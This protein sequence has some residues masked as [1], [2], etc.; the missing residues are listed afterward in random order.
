MPVISATQAPVFD[1]PG[2]RVV[3][4][5]APSRGSTEIAA[6]RLRLAPG[7][8]S[9]E[10]VL[11]AEEVFI[12]LA[13]SAVADLDGVPHRVAAGD[14]LVVPPRVPFRIATDGDVAFEAVA[15]MRAG[16]LATVDSR[17]F[18]PPWAV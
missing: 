6:W 16:G 1:Q 17:T 3:G 2:T 5:A 18:A 13:G 11:T 8:A 14:A 4:L 15:C 12:A 7:A 9:P 10:H